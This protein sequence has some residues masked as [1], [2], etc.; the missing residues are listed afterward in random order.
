MTCLNGAQAT[1]NVTVASG[2]SLVV[3]DSTINGT[4]TS[5]G[6]EAVQLIGSTVNGAAQITGSH[7]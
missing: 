3:K 7:Q 6:A 4:L 5:T 2:A 1:G